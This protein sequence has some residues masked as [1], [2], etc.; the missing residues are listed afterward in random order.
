MLPGPFLCVSYLLQ[1]GPRAS[2]P[3]RPNHY[4][5]RMRV[6][7]AVLT[8]INHLCNHLSQLSPLALTEMR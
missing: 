3:L 7:F 6:G 2:R 5:Q 1:C 4:L 8:E